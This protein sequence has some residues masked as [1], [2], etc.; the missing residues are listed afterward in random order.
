MISI[1][2]LSCQLGQPSCPGP[3]VRLSAGGGRIELGGHSVSIEVS[4]ARDEM[5]AVHPAPPPQDRPVGVLARARILDNKG[6][7]DVALDCARISSGGQDVSVSLT[8]LSRVD[9]GTERVIEAFGQRQMPWRSGETVLVELFARASGQTHVIEF[10]SISI[11]R[12]E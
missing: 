4:A 5:P 3:D 8:E 9:S 11:R 7:D 6:F 2:A 10:P 12:A 1:A